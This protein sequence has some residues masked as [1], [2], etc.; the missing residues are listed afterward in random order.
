MK[1]NIQTDSTKVKNVISLL[2]EKAQASWLLLTSAS[3]SATAQSVS[4]APSGI[5]AP[6]VGLQSRVRFSEV[7]GLMMMSSVTL[8]MCLFACLDSLDLLFYSL[9]KGL[10]VVP[11]STHSTTLPEPDS[12]LDIC[13]SW[14][15]LWLSVRCVLTF[16][17]L[18]GSINKTNN[19]RIAGRES[20]CLSAAFFL[21]VSPARRCSVTSPQ[22]VMINCQ[23]VY[24]QS[25]VSVGRHQQHTPDN[26]L[27]LLS[28]ER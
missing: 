9:N 25:R 19:I 16:W 13:C 14:A 6:D 24:L 28:P 21:W 2:S 26:R 12:G 27:L 22:M 11:I 15:S 10:L 18:Q 1:E 4:V 23:D 3:T 7:R 8:R 17:L 5:W 20:L